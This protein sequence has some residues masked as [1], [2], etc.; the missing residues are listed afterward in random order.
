[1]LCQV[2]LTGVQPDE[3]EV[4]D[5]LFF[6]HYDK[7]E[8]RNGSLIMNFMGGKLCLGTN[9]FGEGCGSCRYMP[10]VVRKILK[11][12][13]RFVFGKAQVYSQSGEGARTGDGC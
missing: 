12:Q 1:M 4:L 6:H 5:A 10:F 7:L 3:K 13:N 11:R 8:E 9:D 2:H